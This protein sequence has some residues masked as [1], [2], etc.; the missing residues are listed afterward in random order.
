VVADTAEHARLVVWR[1]WRFA[2]AV[3]MWTAMHS[4]YDPNGKRDITETCSGVNDSGV[5]P[6]ATRDA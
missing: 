2:R 4:D 5:G 1:W 6:A 3:R